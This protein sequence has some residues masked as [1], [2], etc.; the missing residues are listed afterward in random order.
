MQNKLYPNTFAEGMTLGEER[1]INM[2]LLELETI[3]RRILHG[4]I[5]DAETAIDIAIIKIQQMERIRYTQD[6]DDLK[7][8]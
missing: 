7:E 2:A 1:A 8:G 4:D 6:S 3:H 5:D